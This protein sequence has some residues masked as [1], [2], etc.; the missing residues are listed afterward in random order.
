[1]HTQTRSIHFSRELCRRA[2]RI[3]VLG[4]GSSPFPAVRSNPWTTR[5]FPTH[6]LLLNCLCQIPRTTSSFFLKQFQTSW[7]PSTRLSS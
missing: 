7:T 5:A 4:P 3:L 2:C 6:K 1:M